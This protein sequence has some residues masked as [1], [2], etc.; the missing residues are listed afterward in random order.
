MSALCRAAC[1]KVLPLVRGPL[2]RTA[3]LR[4]MSASSAPG[5]S[6]QGTI[7]YMFVVIAAAA[8]GFYVY[9]TLST[10]RAR[11]HERAADLESRPK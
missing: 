10:D 2:H 8:G 9:R 4:Q 11:F 5:S 7:Y 1:L 3:P 6:G